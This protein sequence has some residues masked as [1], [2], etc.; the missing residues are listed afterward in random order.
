M[1]EEKY[2]RM[3]ER[4]RRLMA[5]AEDPG[6]S[7]SEAAVAWARAQRIMSEYAIED[8]Q[9]HRQDRLNDPIVERK[10][11]LYPDPMNP[12]KAELAGV[13][14]R[15]SRADAYQTSCKARNG[16]KVVKSIV[17]CGTERDCRQAE[18]VWTSMETY[19]ASHWRSAARRRGVKADAGWRNGY[20]GGFNTRISERYHEL[21]CEQE[22]DDSISGS[23]SEL[24]R[25]RGAQVADFMGGLN[26]PTAATPDTWLRM[27][28]KAFKEGADAAE[29]AALGLDELRRCNQ[30]ESKEA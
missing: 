3:L 7:E 25:V 16:R 26:L 21:R 29:R 6:A 23:G 10:V 14:A 18:M 30:I 12:M 9:L 1:K 19:R 15:G 28:A 24:M 2:E 17:F 27:D 11:G 13:V 5:M 4:A 20:Y 8:W 22:E